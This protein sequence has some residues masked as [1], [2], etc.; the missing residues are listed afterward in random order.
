LKISWG[1]SDFEGRVGATNI[2]ANAATQWGL[3]YVHALSKRT[4]LYATTSRLDNDGSLTLAI[5]GGN[6]GMPAG[7]SSKGY[8]AGIRHTF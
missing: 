3:G 6:S 7:G 5:P 2:S 4:V 1:Q 8:E